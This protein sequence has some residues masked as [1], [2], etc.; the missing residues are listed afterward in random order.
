MSVHQLDMLRTLATRHGPINSAFRAP[1]D[2]DNTSISTAHHFE[3][4]DDD[5]LLSKT[6]SNKRFC[7]DPEEEFNAWVYGCPPSS[8]TNL[9]HS[10]DFNDMLLELD[11]FE[12]HVGAD[13]RRIYK[14]SID[15]M[16]TWQTWL[17]VFCSESLRY[18]GLGH[19]QYSRACCNPDCR[20]VL[21]APDAP[22]PLQQGFISALYQ[23]RTCGPA[24]L[25]RRCCIRQ[26]SLS[27]VHIIE[28][29][30]DKFW[31]RILLKSLGLVVQ[32]GHGGFPCASSRSFC[33]ITVIDLCA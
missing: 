19:T 14:N 33:S 28:E 3:L 17:P 18:H 8:Q 10:M 9:P 5:F 7:L 13:G 11:E 26:H 2:E 1:Q 25:C 22:R 23:C 30:R 6:L 32:L 12:T 29:W 16:K 27:P 21:A 20:L 4:D 15:P 31:K 24:V